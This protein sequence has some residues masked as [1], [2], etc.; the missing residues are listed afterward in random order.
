VAVVGGVVAHLGGDVV[1]FA[2]SVFVF[3]GGVFAFFGGAIPFFFGEEGN[4]L[5]GGGVKEVVQFEVDLV[6]EGF[7]PFFG[8]GAL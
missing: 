4:R 5:V 6:G 2:G 7:E 1:F 3:A 8:E